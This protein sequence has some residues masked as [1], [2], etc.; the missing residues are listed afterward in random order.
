HMSF[1]RDWSSDVCS[2]DL[3][4]SQS[5]LCCFLMPFYQLPQRPSGAA[6]Q[7]GRIVP[8]LLGEIT[9]QTKTTAY[10]RYSTTRQILSLQAVL[11]HK[12]GRAS[13]R[14]IVSIYVVE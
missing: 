4:E 14:A 6:A 7:I 12:K 8:I 10:I 3:F 2:S 13:S 5:R 1:S 9:L 11:R